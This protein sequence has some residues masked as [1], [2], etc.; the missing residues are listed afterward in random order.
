ML[1]DK[2]KPVERRGRKAMDLRSARTLIARLPK[3]ASCYQS[4]T[5]FAQ[6]SCDGVGG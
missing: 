4:A 2:G 3:K 1:S 6:Q 5:Q